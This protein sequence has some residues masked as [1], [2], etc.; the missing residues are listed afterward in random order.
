MHRVC[1]HVDFEH[2]NHSSEFIRYAPRCWGSALMHTIRGLCFLCAA[3]VL[4][5]GPSS[6]PNA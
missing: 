4:T 1:G 3:A 6:D 5:C 2:Q